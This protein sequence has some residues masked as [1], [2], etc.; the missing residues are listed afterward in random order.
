MLSW[1]QCFNYYLR[2]HT[3]HWPA[4]SCFDCRRATFPER[5]ENSSVYHIWMGS[6][7]LFVYS[8]EMSCAWFLK[9]QAIYWLS[10]WYRRP[11]HEWS[12]QL[13]SLIKRRHS[14]L[15]GCFDEAHGVLDQDSS[16]ELCSTLKGLCLFQ[17]NPDDLWC[18]SPGTSKPRDNASGYHEATCKIVNS[19]LMRARPCF[20][21]FNPP[22]LWGENP[23]TKHVEV[24]LAD[25]TIKNTIVHT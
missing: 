25:K 24:L 22:C 5:S 10:V 4:G 2:K 18:W 16:I 20:N 12:R 8:R 14:I 15:M 17:T 6:P 19:Y 13:G 7:D 11:L 21:E 9:P 3:M 23:S 1:A